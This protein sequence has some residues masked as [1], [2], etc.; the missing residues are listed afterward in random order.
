M[1]GTEVQQQL[2]DFFIPGELEISGKASLE[3]W[4]FKPAFWYSLM[5]KD[6]ATG[7]FPAKPKTLKFFSV[8]YKQETISFLSKS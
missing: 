4:G 8:M 5:S 2:L 1:K 6:N 7:N 3:Q